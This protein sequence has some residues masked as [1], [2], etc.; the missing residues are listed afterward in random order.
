[1][2]TEYTQAHRTLIAEREELANLDHDYTKARAEILARMQ[3]TRARV[4]QGSAGLDLTRIEI[5]ERVLSVR[6][7]YANGGEKRDSVVE[8]AI[9]DIARGPFILRRGYMG[10]KNYDKWLGQRCDCNYGFGPS[11]GSI[12]FAIGLRDLGEATSITD[13]ERDACLYYLSNLIAIQSATTTPA[14][15]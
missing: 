6:G 9:S 5:A 4:R 1:M 13:E 11:H 2:S 12:V 14:R 15:E 3:E 10:T 7:T 8:D